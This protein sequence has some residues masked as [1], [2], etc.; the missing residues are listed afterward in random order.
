MGCLLFAD[1][2]DESP[3][4]VRCVLAQPTPAH[5]DLLSRAAPAV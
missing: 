2:F 4:A 5:A 3:Y 1:R